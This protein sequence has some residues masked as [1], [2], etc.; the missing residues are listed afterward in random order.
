MASIIHLW[1][2]TQLFA[3]PERQ[4]SWPQYP[5]FVMSV[6]LCKVNMVC[7][8]TWGTLG[9]LAALTDLSL[10][11][12][13]FFGCI[14]SKCLLNC[15]HLFIAHCHLCYIILY[16]LCILLLGKGHTFFMNVTIKKKKCIVKNCVLF[17][18]NTLTVCIQSNATYFKTLLY[19]FNHSEQMYC[20]FTKDFFRLYVWL[21]NSMFPL[22]NPAHVASYVITFFK[23][24][25]TWLLTLCW[26]YIL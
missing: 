24:Y 9:D 19:Y 26:Q 17:S 4:L 23:H 12:K 1:L 3:H 8:R 14:Y 11:I 7:F 13:H 15:S 22:I 18:V 21:L 2:C 10:K 20:S 16:W 25:G 5:P 6:E